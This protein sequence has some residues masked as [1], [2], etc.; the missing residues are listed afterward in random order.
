MK[1][2]MQVEAAFG[3]EEEPCPVASQGCGTWMQR[4]CSCFPPGFEEFR[5]A[6]RGPYLGTRK[7]TQGACFSPRCSAEMTKVFRRRKIRNLEVVE[8]EGKT[9][10]HSLKPTA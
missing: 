6:R 1:E 9:L 8:L 2:S 5:W 4:N 7:C 10:H 3:E